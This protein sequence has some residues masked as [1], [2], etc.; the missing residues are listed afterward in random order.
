M[1]YKLSIQKKSGFNYSVENGNLKI[2][3]SIIEEPTN[4]NIIEYD[5]TEAETSLGITKCYRENEEVICH[6]T[7]F[8]D[9]LEPYKTYKIKEGK[10]SNQKSKWDFTK[11]M[12]VEEVING[13]PQVE[14]IDV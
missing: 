1:K 5:M 12:T 9:D 8:V 4:T 10:L 14:V 3:D 2:N 11:L 6:L 13:N 7:K